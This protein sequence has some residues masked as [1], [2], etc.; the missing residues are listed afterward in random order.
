MKYHHD[1]RF[2]APGPGAVYT[3]KLLWPDVPNKYLAEAIY[4][5]RENAAE[6][7]LT[8][9]V[10]FH[11]S[12]YNIELDNGS[13]LFNEQQNGLKYYGTEVLCC[14]Y[15]VYLQI[16]DDEKACGRRQ[17]A[18]AKAPQNTLTEFF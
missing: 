16:R 14:Q 3:I 15:G 7:G 13:Y 9:D 18:R 2:V 12:G 11:E 5:I 17:V 10:V 4:F 6:I 8:K 1:Q